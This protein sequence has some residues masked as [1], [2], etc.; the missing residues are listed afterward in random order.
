MMFVFSSTGSDVTLHFPNRSF[1]FVFILFAI[2]SKQWFDLLSI[3]F[4]ALSCDFLGSKYV[5]VHWFVDVLT[6]RSKTSVK[7]ETR[8]LIILSVKSIHLSA[9]QRYKKERFFPPKSILILIEIHSFTWFSFGSFDLILLGLILLLH[10]RAYITTWKLLHLCR[11]ISSI[12]TFHD[13]H[14]YEKEFRGPL[15]SFYRW[16][17]THRWGI[18]HKQH[19]RKA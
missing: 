17:F 10:Y 12:S 7:A 14:N 2:W 5:N 6:K 16:R 15:I 19:W 4:C 18:I 11:F 9:L 13:T 8:S 1:I 3:S